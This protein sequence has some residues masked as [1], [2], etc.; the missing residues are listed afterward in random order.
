MHE[1]ENIC[2]A[3]CR[4]CQVILLNNEVIKVII[5]A[6]LRFGMTNMTDCLFWCKTLCQNNGGQTIEEKLV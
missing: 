1:H 3:V 5:H 2:I 6:R 4:A